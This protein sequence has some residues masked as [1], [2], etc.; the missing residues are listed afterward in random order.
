MRY[1]RY[2]TGVNRR[3]RDA[4][5][6]N[7]SKNRFSWSVPYRPYH[8]NAQPIEHTSTA[9]FS[10]PPEEP[11]GSLMSDIITAGLRK[12]VNKNKIN[13]NIFPLGPGHTLSRLFGRKQ[14]KLPKTAGTSPLP[15]SGGETLPW[16]GSI[17]FP[18]PSFPQEGKGGFC[19]SPRRL[20]NSLEQAPL[21]CWWRGRPLAGGLHRE[22]QGACRLVLRRRMREKLGKQTGDRLT[23]TLWAGAPRPPG[24]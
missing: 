18:P 16:N 15:P 20:P 23:V 4:A 6:E 17:L 3:I 19:P 10:T 9:F 8:Q 2:H 22:P 13:R 5:I 24:R 11:P 7:T 12:I 21:P 1:P 14:G